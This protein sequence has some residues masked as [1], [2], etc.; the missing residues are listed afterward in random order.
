M[1]YRE[2]SLL[3]GWP[4]QGIAVRVQDGWTAEFG[5]EERNHGDRGSVR[6]PGN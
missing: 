1:A 3:N 4:E 2:P 5:F 6:L